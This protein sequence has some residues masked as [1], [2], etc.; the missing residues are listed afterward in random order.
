MRAFDPNGLISEPVRASWPAPLP[1]LDYFVS[2][3]PPPGWCF[4]PLARRRAMA[5]AL[6]PH[7]R[8]TSRDGSVGWD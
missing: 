7:L 4:C 2:A 3:D 8:I 6:L 5:P 1:G